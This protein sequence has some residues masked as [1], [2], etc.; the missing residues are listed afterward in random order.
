MNFRTFALLCVACGTLSL[1]SAG[2]IIR[3]GPPPREVVVEREVVVDEPPPVERVYIYEEGYPP[4][5]YRCG[6]YY[7]YG[8][9]RY[10]RNVFITKV[11]NVNIH[12]HRYVNVV[13]NR[14]VSHEIEHQH[15]VQYQQKQQHVQ[16]Q[17]HPQY[18]GQSGQP[19]HPVYQPQQTKNEPN[20]KRDSRDK[21]K[22]KDRDRDR[23]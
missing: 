5:S 14:R 18:N 13:E 12:E 11:V 19:V 8:G 3:E 21:D 22:D 1:L 6:D 17:Q 16:A 9:Y 10:E 4:G 20:K 15:V 7:Y 23:N 2:C